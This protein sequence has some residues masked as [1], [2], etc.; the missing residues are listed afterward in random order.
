MKDHIKNS[1]TTTRLHGRNTF[2]SLLY[3]C[4]EFV[5]MFVFQQSQ[6]EPRH[7]CNTQTYY[8]FAGFAKVMIIIRLGN[9]KYKQS[10]SFRI[11]NEALISGFRHHWTRTKTWL[12]IR[13]YLIFLPLQPAPNRLAENLPPAGLH[14]LVIVTKYGDI[15]H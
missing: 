11:A 7:E 10:L 3:A 1:I 14:C 15:G 4:N 9:V 12:S 8:G 6:V 13:C 5:L 2:R